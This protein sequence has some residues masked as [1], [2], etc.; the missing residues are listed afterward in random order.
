MRK[1]GGVP[2]LPVSIMGPLLETGEEYDGTDGNIQHPA[3]TDRE[4]SSSEICQ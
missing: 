2:S 3:S 1:G 4:A